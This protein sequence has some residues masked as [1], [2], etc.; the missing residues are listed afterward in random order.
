MEGVEDIPGT[1]LAEGMTWGW[2]TFPEYLDALEAAALDRST[3]A[4]RSPTAPCAP[5]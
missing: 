2:E 3:S 1:A 5:T 4:P